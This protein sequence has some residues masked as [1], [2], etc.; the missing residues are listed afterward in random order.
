MEQAVLGSEVLCVSCRAGE[1]AVLLW[2]VL[3]RGSDPCLAAVEGPSRKS[4]CAQ[5]YMTGELL[6][7]D[8]G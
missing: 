5:D 7:V 8:C 1:C 2:E 3:Y 4:N 6:S